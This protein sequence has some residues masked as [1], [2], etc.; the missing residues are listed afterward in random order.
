MINDFRTIDLGFLNEETHSVKIAL[1]TI[2][3]SN[4][5][6]LDAK[7]SSVGKHVLM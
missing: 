3:W 5:M 1:A 2:S 4:D 7:P 6:A